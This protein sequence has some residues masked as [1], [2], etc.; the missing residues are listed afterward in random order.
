MNSRLSRRKFLKGLGALA[1]L[2]SVGKWLSMDGSPNITATPTYNLY[3][4]RNGTP[5]TNVAKAVE[6]AGG[7]QNFVDYGD[8]V[9][10][11]PNG[12]WPNQ[13]YTHTQCLKALIDLVL[14]RPGGFGGEVIIA[15]NIH[16]DPTEAMKNNYCWNMSAG[17]RLNNWPDMNYLGLVA[18][19][20]GRGINNVTACPLY[21]SGQG[22]WQK[23]TGPAAVASGKQGWVHTTYLVTKNNRTVDL[24]YPIIRSTYSGKLIDLKNGVWSGGSYTGQKVKLICLPTLNNHGGGISDEDYAGPTSAMK[25]HIGFVDFGNLDGYSLHDIGYSG[26]VDPQAM[27]EAVGYFVSQVIHPSFYLTCAEYTGHISRTDS[28]AAHTKTVG[29]C[30]EPATLDYWMCKHIVYPIANQA[31]MNPDNTNNLRRALDG[32][33][34]KGVGALDESQIALHMFDFGPNRI[35]VPFVSKV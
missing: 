14:N 25:T 29:L 27:G 15:E 19:Y 24:S 22:N 2:P 21:D 23:V 3:V 33:R 16:R 9:V 30:A 17:N 26:P 18:D 13:G 35:Y 8:A 32:C 7:I 5:V 34:S 4:S 1:A 12:Q 31:F 20:H 10:L 11:K 28:T 6:L